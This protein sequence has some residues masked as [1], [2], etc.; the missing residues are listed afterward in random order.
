MHEHS[1]LDKKQHIGL[2]PLLIRLLLGLLVIGK[3]K[4][5]AI[6]FKVDTTLL[7]ASLNI[8]LLFL[9]FLVLQDPCNYLWILG[10]NSFSF[11]L[12][13][14]TKVGELLLL[15]LV[16]MGVDF[17]EC[18]ENKHVTLLIQK[19]MYTLKFNVKYRKS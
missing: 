5:S 15:F 3:S 2:K 9:Y 4:T 18:T 17:L 1:C 8:S 14:Q 6:L 10:T 7:A 12:K 13:I 19:N 16:L 11:T